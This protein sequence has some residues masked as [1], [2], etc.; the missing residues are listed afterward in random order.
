MSN[1]IIIEQ[2]GKDVRQVKIGMYVGLDT[3]VDKGRQVKIGRYVG[4]GR[5]RS[6]KIGKYVGRDW[7]VDRDR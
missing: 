7:Q 1:V 4:R 3:L 2:V 6:E 5:G